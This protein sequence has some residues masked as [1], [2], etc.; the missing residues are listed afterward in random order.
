[1]TD[2][3]LDDLDRDGALVEAFD[4]LHARTRADLLR[5][6]VVGSVAL[7]TAVA[8]PAGAEEHE[9]PRDISI[10]TF[11]LT[12][13]QLQ[14]DFYTETQRNR[15]LH[16][17]L[18]AQATVVGSHE[19]AHARALHRALESHGQAAALRLRRR[20]RGRRRI[21]AH[22]GRLRGPLGRGLQGPGAAHRR[23]RVPDLG[24]G[25]PLRGARHAAWIRRLAG[26]A[27]V[28]GPFDEPISRATT[29]RIVDRTHFVVR[30][31][32]RRG[33]RFTG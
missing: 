8:A 22:R 15:V 18:E 25:H 10:L 6:A 29:T 27:P 1:M 20:H 7:L 30:T 21:P 17:A 32:S 5:G 12:L 33:P 28:A 13:E 2:L 11:M 19:R 31:T 14:A 9:S 24:D 4:G 26:Q 3:P 23:A 16:G